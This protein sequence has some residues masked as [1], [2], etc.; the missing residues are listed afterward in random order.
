MRVILAPA[1]EDLIESEC[2][3]VQQGIVGGSLVQ[4][5]LQHILGH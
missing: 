4:N 1:L 2:R 3:I 5:G